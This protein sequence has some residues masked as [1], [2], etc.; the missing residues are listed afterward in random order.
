VLSVENKGRYSTLVKETTTRSQLQRMWDKYGYFLV[1]P[2]DSKP[3]RVL[4]FGT[5]TTPGVTDMFN[6]HL[7]DG[8]QLALVRH[9]IYKPRF[10]RT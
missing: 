3:A 10:L 4:E 1:M 5:D 9:E 8:I 2:V 7:A 6:V